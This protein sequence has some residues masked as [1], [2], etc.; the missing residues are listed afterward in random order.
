[1]RR[2]PIPELLTAALALNLCVDAGR[3]VVR[4]VL[5]VKGKTQEKGAP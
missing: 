2:P 3:K 4:F 1:M 5:D